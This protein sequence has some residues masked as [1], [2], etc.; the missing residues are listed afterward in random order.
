MIV[1]TL[2]RLAGELPPRLLA[3]QIP[4]FPEV[5]ALG[6]L[7]QNLGVDPGPVIEQLERHGVDTDALRST[8]QQARPL[9]DLAVDDI[10]ALGLDLL[11]RSIPVAAQL[12]LPL[13]RP[14]ATAQLGVMA[15]ETLTLAGQRLVT[16]AHELAPLAARLDRIA[17]ENHPEPD[18]PLPAPVEAQ[19]H[20]PSPAAQ[21]EQE[22]PV[23]QQASA[24]G[25]ATVDGQAGAGGQA[26]VAAALGQVGTPYVWGGTTPAG[27]DCSGLVQW[28]YAQAGIELPRT[29][30]EMAMG[31][32][33]NYEDLRPGDL[34]VWDG[35]VAMYTGDGMMVEAG[36]PVQTNPVRTSNIGMGF[37]GF[38]RPTG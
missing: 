23:M 4:D 7:A 26:A 38:W 34:A 10:T 15:T 19:P 13:L 31:Q 9:I 12:P 21:A 29:A 16:L 24:S 32:Q 33:V 30:A 2:H 5:S 37:L 1:E 3:P 25:Q 11:R 14:A 8:A 17:L 20:A 36:D 22:M 6:P 18:P 28:S 35:H 27:F